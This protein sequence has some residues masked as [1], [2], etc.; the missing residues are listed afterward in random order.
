MS[1]WMTLTVVGVQYLQAFWFLPIYPLFHPPARPQLLSNSSLFT[2]CGFRVLWSVAPC[3]I[4]FPPKEQFIH[5]TNPAIG[6]ATERPFLF[7][8]Q[9]GFNHEKIDPYLLGHQGSAEGGRS[10]SLTHGFGAMAGER[11]T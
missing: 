11:M 7:K 6:T 10:D 1:I 4:I 5:L 3:A 9:R 8:D 2:Q